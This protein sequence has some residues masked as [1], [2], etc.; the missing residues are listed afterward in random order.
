MEHE[1]QDQLKEILRGKDGQG[2]IIPPEKYKELSLQETILLFHMALTEMQNKLNN[3]GNRRFFRM[4]VTTFET[5]TSLKLWEQPELYVLERKE[6]PVYYTE[7]HPKSGD[8]MIFVFNTQE[9]AEAVAGRMAEKKINV[10]IKTVERSKYVSFFL[11]LFNGGV[12]AVR[13]NAEQ[14]IF[15]LPLWE[16]CNKINDVFIKEE[17]RP[18]VKLWVQRSVYMV[19]RKGGMAPYVSLMAPTDDPAALEGEHDK[20]N[21]LA[22]IYSDK[23]QAKRKVRALEAEGESV[24]SRLILNRQFYHTFLNMYLLGAGRIETHIGEDEHTVGL[25]QMLAKPDATQNHEA[26]QMWNMKEVYYLEKKD[27]DKEF[28]NLCLDRSEQTKD[29]QLFMFTSHSGAQEAARKMTEQSPQLQVEVKTVENSRFP[30]FYL[31]LLPRGITSINLDCDQNMLLIPLRLI[32]NKLRDVFIKEESRSSVKFWVQEK[33]Y[34]L[35]SNLTNLPYVECD[36]ETYD[37]QAYVFDNRERAMEA[38]NMLAEQKIPVRC[39][40]VANQMFYNTFYTLH[41]MGVN[42]LKGEIGSNVLALQLEQLL[43][44]PDYSKIPEKERPVEN[45]QFLLTAVYIYQ[46]LRRQLPE[47]ERKAVEELKEM[48][49]EFYADLRKG[50]FIVPV[51]VSKE[52]ENAGQLILPII[53]TKNQEAYWPI[54]TDKQAAKVFEDFQVQRAQEEKREKTPYRYLPMNYEQ[55]MKLMPE[56]VQG[57][58]I[59]PHTINI[60]M[61]KTGPDGEKKEA[62]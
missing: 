21:G 49:E 55:L 16:I 32:C 10:N 40:C 35:Y 17:S 53:Y 46:E 38:V 37:D 20:K 39:E 3:E 26:W 45:P 11:N 18:A 62:L 48:Q 42:A 14:N 31:S 28:W 27:K 29:T 51:D 52:G 47:E 4:R 43:P 19:C 8:Q 6:L 56:Q 15:I 41:M 1:R 36:P 5:L 61:K 23:V 25:T 2:Q 22:Y 30:A 57:I 34:M 9:G 50:R 59:N 60:L 7:K 44:K 12:S 24:E 54:L 58:V 33:V 13:I